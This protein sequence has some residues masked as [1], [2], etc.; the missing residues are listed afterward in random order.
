MQG[1]NDIAMVILAVFLEERLKRPLPESWESGAT[2]EAS[3][4]GISEGLKITYVKRSR[5][6]READAGPNNVE[7]TRRCCQAS[8]LHPIQRRTA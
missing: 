4:E 1:I 5:T 6:E 2:D 3:G 8:S 7:L